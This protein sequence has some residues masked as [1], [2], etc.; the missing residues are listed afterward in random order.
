[1]VLKKALLLF[2]KQHGKEVYYQDSCTIVHSELNIPYGVKGDDEIDIS[3][4]IVRHEYVRV[5]ELSDALSVFVPKGMEEN[6][7]C[8]LTNLIYKFIGVFKNDNL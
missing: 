3:K 5:M 2:G 1:M 8:V 7:K 6:F 4:F